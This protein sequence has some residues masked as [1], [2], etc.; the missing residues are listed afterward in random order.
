MR[1]HHILIQGAGRGVGLAL[2]QQ[3]L[4][5]DN[6]CISATVREPDNADTLQALA[7]QYGGERLALFALDLSDEA[8]IETARQAVGRRHPRLDLMMIC[9]G[10][11]HDDQGLWPEKKLAD[12]DPDHLARSFTVNASGPILMIKHFHA[13][14][15]HGERAVIA[16]LSARIGSISD[17]GLGDWYAYR[18][19]KATQNQLTRT[20]SIE[21]KRKFKRLICV[22]LHPG[23]VDTGLSRPFQ[24][25]VPENQL[26]SAER[27]AGHLLDVAARLTPDDSGQLF[28]WAG[29]RIQP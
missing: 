24:K 16:S 17:N 5:R 29:E 13:L 8:S 9:A 3:L 25:R 4:R 21:L 6:V 15:S 10:L 18:A 23:T 14:L 27:A 26:Q 12:I 20:A 28:D 19:A 22:G 1:E 11:L 2:V 7:L